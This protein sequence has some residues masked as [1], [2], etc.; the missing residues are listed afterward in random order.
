M[1]MMI[2]VMNVALWECL[3]IAILMQILAT[4]ATIRALQHQNF[5]SFFWLEKYFLRVSRGRSQLL[6]K[7]YGHSHNIAASLPL[8]LIILQP[9]KNLFAAPS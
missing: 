4:C 5:N 3:P 8:P 9:G 6:E 1:M 2:R 7:C